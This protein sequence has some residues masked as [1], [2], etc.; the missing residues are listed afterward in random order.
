[1]NIFE[2][3]RSGLKMALH[4]KKMTTV[5]YSTTL[6]LGLLIALPFYSVMNNEVGSSASIYPMLREFDYTIFSD[7]LNNYG[8]SIRPFISQ[9]I[10]FALFYSVVSVFF[11]GGILRIL[12][13]KDKNFSLRTFFGGCGAYFARLVKLAL[14]ILAAHGIIAA[15]IYIPLILIISALGDG[16]ESEAA[17]FYIILTGV[18]IHI[19]SLLLI[20]VI[21]DYSKVIIVVSESRKVFKSFLHSLK[22]VM[23]HL[24]KIYS[25]YLLL[26][27]FPFVLLLIYFL[28]DELVG[29]VSG[30]TV[31]IMFLIQQIFIWF[32]IWAK[33][34]IFGSELYFLHAYSELGILP[35]ETGV[36]E[37]K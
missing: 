6:V 28:S 21:S 2:A 11:S 13:D 26:L 31:I 17:Y 18:I 22:F 35:R 36:L 34:W 32:R 4:S 33:I 23:R 12:S 3:Y 19:I 29:M 8:N 27:I 37:N 5:I 9:I 15:V 25:L 1:M 10:W 20:I 30:I 16:F 7:V 14:I 24:F